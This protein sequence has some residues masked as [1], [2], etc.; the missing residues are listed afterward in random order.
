MS[1][2]HRSSPQISSSP[3]VSCFMCARYTGEPITPAI[4][5][6]LEIESSSS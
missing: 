3:V 1:R 4:I 5:E 6:L 2:A